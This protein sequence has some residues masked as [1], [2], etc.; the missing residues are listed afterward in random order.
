MINQEILSSHDALCL[1]SDE[2]QCR[3]NRRPRAGDRQVIPDDLESLS[4]KLAAW[5]SAHC[6]CRVAA[7]EV[8]VSAWACFSHWQI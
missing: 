5:K 2:I 4:R 1:E 7:Y 8:P 6:V 3:R